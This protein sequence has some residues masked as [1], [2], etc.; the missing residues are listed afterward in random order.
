MAPA[1]LMEKTSK[2]LQPRMAC[3]E[4]KSEQSMKTARAGFGLE[5]M[6]E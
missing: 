1:G 3:R 5:P 6:P 2:P 4:M